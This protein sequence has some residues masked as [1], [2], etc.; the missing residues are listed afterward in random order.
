MGCDLAKPAC[1]DRVCQWASWKK[2]IWEHNR[3]KINGQGSMFRV[4]WQWKW[5]S[6]HIAVINCDSHLWFS[7]F[8]CAFP[9]FWHVRGFP[10]MEPHWCF[11]S[12]LVLRAGPRFRFRSRACRCSVAKFYTSQP[13]WARQSLHGPLLRHHGI[14]GSK[15]L[16]DVLRT[17]DYVAIYFLIPGTMMPAGSQDKL[18]FAINL[19]IWTRIDCWRMLT[20]ISSHC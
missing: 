16:M 4:W 14:K 11:C 3:M 7:R 18:Q 17:L 2:T 19:N 12:L 13:H 15:R 10:S 20:D 6:Q 5:V 1:F 9:G 8:F